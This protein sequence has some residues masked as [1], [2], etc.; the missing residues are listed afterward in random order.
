MAKDKP[1]RGEVWDADLE[2]SRGHEQ[3][4]KRPVLVVSA[5][6]FNQGP[7]GL[8]IAIPISSKD[9]RVRTQVPIEADEAGLRVRSFAKCEAVRSI[10]LERLSRRRG[11]VLS[12]TM[13]RVSLVL[14]ILLDL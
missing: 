6:P 2:P 3:G 4:G 8:V 12:E 10:S 13:A 14:R 1:A 11:R 9:K 7:S 5:D